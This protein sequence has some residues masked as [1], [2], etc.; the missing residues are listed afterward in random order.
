[1]PALIAV[2]FF[3]RV[4]EYVGSSPVT[5]GIVLAVAAIDAFF[6]LVP[7]ET[8]VIAAGTL[9]A[10]GDLLLYLVIPAAALG[11]FAGDNVSYALGDV[12]G[13]RAAKRVFSGSKGRARM[14]KAQRLLDRYGAPVIVLA[15]FVP[16]G[17]TATTFAAGTLDLTWKRF[18]V[19]DAIAA[20]VWAGYAGMIG[21]LG[22]SAFREDV[23]KALALGFGIALAV[24][25]GVEIVRRIQAR[26]GKDLLI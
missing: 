19:Y 11:A 17:R 15:R 24:A 6:P 5:Y 13:E 23:W 21:Y 7:S 26:R 9:A 3:D 18:L 20:T 8:V 10:S 14:R 2:S 12:F 1:M 16:G 4:T 22:G 25:G